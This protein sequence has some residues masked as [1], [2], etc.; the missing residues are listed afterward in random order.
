MKL[1]DYDNKLVRI[2][3]I[4]G[5]TYEGYCSHNSRDYNYHEYNRDI[6]G[7]Q[8]LPFLFFKDDIKKIEVIKD[9]SD[10]KYGTLEKEIFK[11]GIELIDEVLSSEDNIHIY[12]MLLCIKDNYKELKNKEKLNKI[13][14]DLIKY[15]NDE[16]VVRESKNIEG[17]WKDLN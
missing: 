8:L 17:L 5:N 13:L 12:R 11:E 6:E 2:E 7:V 9:F 4:D 3:C 15:N 16:R 14:D 10:K 1:V